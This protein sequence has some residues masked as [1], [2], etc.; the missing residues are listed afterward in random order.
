M[1]TATSEPVSL[2]A[3]VVEGLDLRAHSRLE[4]LVGPEWYRLLKGVVTN[5]LSVTGLIIIALFILTAV[6]APVLAPPIRDNWDTSLIPRDG[7]RSEPQ[8]P[9]AVWQRDAPQT[10]P[11]WY[12]ALTGKDEWVHLF[13]TASGQYDI[14]YGVVWGTR[15][16]LFIGGVVVAASAV[17][18]ILIGSIAGFYGGW[19]DEILMRFVEVFIA[20]PF[21]VAA[22]ILAAALVPI[23]GQSIWPASIALIVF[24]WTTYA[25][26]LRG[27]IL[28]TKEREY[29]TAARAAGAKDSHLILRHIL[30]N[31]IFPT[32]VVLSLDM[33]SIVLSFAALSFLGVGTPV[34]YTD[35]GQI[36]SFARQ[37]ILSLDVYWYII[38]FPGLALLFYGLGWNLVGDALRD[39]LDPKMRGRR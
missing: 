6:F 12:K 39:I 30:P 9:G 2:N 31:A 24:G 1:T 18:G 37:W 5:P 14:Y 10:I 23:I 17:I 33:G 3:P 20:F 38:V 21:L 13:G 8:P 32:L 29:V 22:L 35:W 26:L 19:V 25:R 34:G 4:Q 16:A 27:D 28:S 7:F 15:T 36:V 11:F